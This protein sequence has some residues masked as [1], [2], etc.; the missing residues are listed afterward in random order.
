[1]NIDFPPFNPAE[2]SATALFQG[3]WQ[4]S[5]PL[6]ILGVVVLIRA[7]ARRRITRRTAGVARYALTVSAFAFLA[8]LVALALG[9]VLAEPDWPSVLVLIL[10]PSAVSTALWFAVL[11]VRRADES[12]PSLRDS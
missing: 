11:R 8:F 5:T 2:E 12:A 6:A 3:L 9:G 1:M 4:L 10:G 7:L